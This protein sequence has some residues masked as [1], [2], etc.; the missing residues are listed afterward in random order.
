LKKLKAQAAAD[1]TKAALKA[2]EDE[3][4]RELERLD[5]AAAASADA[6]YEEVEPEEELTEEEVIA[7]LRRRDPSTLNSKERRRLRKA[8]EGV[9]MAAGALPFD[10]GPS[11]AGHGD[12]MGM[13]QG[14]VAH[15]GEWQMAKG[16][17]PASS[18]GGPSNAAVTAAPMPT[19]GTA[20][21]GSR[22]MTDMDEAEERALAY[23]LRESIK[24]EE[25]RKQRQ[26]SQ[27]TLTSAVIATPPAYVPRLA[28]STDPAAQTTQGGPESLQSRPVVLTADGRL[29]AYGA[30]SLNLISRMD[31][32]MFACTGNTFDECLQV[33]SAFLLPNAFHDLLTQLN[34]LPSSCS[35]DYLA[36]LGK[37]GPRSLN[38]S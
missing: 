24:D 9:F 21:T 20:G 4:A 38:L 25:A 5:Q 10:A 2:R 27:S 35:N 22:A 19:P 30:R 37:I 12:V 1:A 17:R 31:G 13:A 16:Q 32:V 11:V 23:A 33:R 8:D 36:C 7:A 6:Q 26:A 14:N 29:T 18:G 15:S 3:D 28:G 34:V